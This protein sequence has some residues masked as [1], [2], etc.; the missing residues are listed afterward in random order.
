MPCLALRGA[1]LAESQHGGSL[2][3]RH[4]FIRL[5]SEA[6]YVCF[7]TRGPSEPCLIA[8]YSTCCFQLVH[9]RLGVVSAF[10]KTALTLTPSIRFVHPHKRNS[11]PPYS[12]LLL[13]QK[14]PSTI[15]EPHLT[16]SKQIDRNGR[17]IDFQKQKGKLHI[18]EQEFKQAE[19]IEYWRQKEVTRP[20]WSSFGDGFQRVGT[21]LF[22]VKPYNIRGEDITSNA[23]S[24]KLWR[25]CRQTDA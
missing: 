17:V 21:Y 18:I 20:L 16:Y 23:S 25:G 5:F 12:S 15:T 19:R 4:Y 13:L 24:C 11:T 7:R 10:L 22:M 3:L 8:G 2:Q 14:K 9:R 1:F 6:S